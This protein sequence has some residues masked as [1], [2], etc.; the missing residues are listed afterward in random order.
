MCI[1][2]LVLAA[3]P[4]GAPPPEVD[5]FREGLLFHLAYLRQP[6]G[7]Y[8]PA[9]GKK[10][11]LLATCDAAFLRHI[12][13]GLPAREE[14]Q[15]WIE[16]IQKYQ[17][18]HTGVF[19]GKL[20][21]FGMA[22]RALNILG[23]S[24]RHPLRFLDRWKDPEALIRWLENL[25]WRE[26][27][28]TSIEVLHVTTPRLLERGREDRIWG[29][30]FFR[31]LEE[32]QDGKTGFWGTNRGASLWIGM[33]GTFHIVPPYRAAGRPLPRPEAMIDSTLKLQER[34]GS[35]RGGYGQMDA[36]HLLMVLTRQTP[37]RKEE[38]RRA[39]GNVVDALLGE[40]DPRAR[41]LG[42]VRDL[43]DLLADYQA[44]GYALSLH[45]DHPLAKISWQDAW[46]PRLWR[47]S[48]ARSDPG[49]L[50]AEAWTVM[51]TYAAV[52]VSAG[53]KERLKDYAGAAK[54]IFRELDELLS[55]YKPE[56]EISRLNRSSG[57]EPVP[58]SG[59]TLEVL[60]HS[61]RYAGL[62]S[63]CFD[64]TVVPLVRLWGFGGGEPP[65]RV[66]PPAELKRVLGLVG[67]QH[68]VLAE[69]SARLELPGMGVDTGGIAKGY[70]VDV[71]YS[72]LL[73]M[74]AA[75]VMVNL[76]G[77]IR[78]RGFPRGAGPWKIGVRNP[79]QR[80]LI[81]GVLSLTGG[82]AVATSGNYE[83]FVTI[84]GKR[85]SHI[86][87]PR[88]GYPAQGMAGVT[89]ISETALEAD[90]LSTALFI[91]GIE[92]SRPVLS[93]LPSSEALFIP[94]RKPLE[95]WLTP[96]FQK[97]FTPNPEHAGA[98]RIIKER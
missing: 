94:D 8:R 1:F 68:L 4:G 46:D 54:K 78:C 92:G 88:T 73:E 97:H 5:A 65:K 48:E 64:P 52:T 81:V 66:P 20:H 98:V 24:P 55:N 10:P 16:A 12:I 56:S 22:L 44:L 36:C 35:F 50:P 3:L 27:W 33:G 11:T 53:E 58:L 83:R 60:R 18:P 14:R 23:G 89:V 90:A 41:L 71:A 42:G 13:S 69:N 43:H 63:G 40:W 77:N 28:G 61:L 93:R 29:D 82:M 9:P 17:D 21:R 25:D 19:E 84:G 47:I 7:S 59:P 30:R 62:T 34:D 87:D 57:K 32:N 95:I 39:L 51:G 38:I 80:D 79:F 70:A 15:R 85:Y 49:P 2:F 75:S 67:Y 45:P 76:G 31:W 37:H 26:T 91:L 74:D 6:D 72:R 96:G 86:L